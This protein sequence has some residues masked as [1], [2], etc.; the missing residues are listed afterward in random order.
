M[1]ISI[2]CIFITLNETFIFM[3]SRTNMKKRKEN[4]SIE[5]EYRLEPIHAANC[6]CVFGS[7][8]KTG[9]S[10]EQSMT[11]SYVIKLL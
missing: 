1:C 2:Q 11:R 3:V 4:S 8:Q 5:M 9:S 6:S 7:A 10:C